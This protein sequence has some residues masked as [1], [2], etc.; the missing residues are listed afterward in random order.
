MKH[1]LEDT[2]PE[3]TL[4]EAWRVLMPSIKTPDLLKRIQVKGEVIRIEAHHWDTS[5]DA[6]KKELFDDIVILGVLGEELK[7]RTTNGCDD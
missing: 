6:R 3:L 7:R 5:S 4:E 1:S 2:I